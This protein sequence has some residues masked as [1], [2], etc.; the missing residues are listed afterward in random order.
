MGSHI[1]LSFVQPLGT[2]HYLSPGGWRNL[3]FFWWEGGHFV[4]RRKE[5]GDQ[6]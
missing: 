2:G 5:A 6:S 1:L 4:F 3:F